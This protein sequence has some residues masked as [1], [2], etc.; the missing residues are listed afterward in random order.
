MK[1]KGMEKIRQIS[2]TFTLMDSQQ[3]KLRELTERYNALMQTNET[4]ESMFSFIMRTGSLFT[5]EKAMD[6]YDKS[7]VALETC[8]FCGGVV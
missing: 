8:G 3:Q 7:L 2:V 1:G 5:I 4:E 6:Q